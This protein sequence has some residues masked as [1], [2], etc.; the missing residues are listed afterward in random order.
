MNAR[1][2]MFKQ[3]DQALR[4]TLLA[5]GVGGAKIAE[6]LM[7]CH[8]CAQDG[9]HTDNPLKIIGNVADDQTFHGLWVSPDIDTL[10]YT[11]ADMIDR[12]KGWGLKGD[13]D[14]TLQAL[15]RLGRETWMFLGD[16]DFATHI[17]RTEQR[18]LGIRPSEIA[19][20]IARQL[21]VKAEILLPTDDVIQS[22]VSTDKGWLDFQDYFVRE[23][24][25][26]A[27]KS[28]TV[29]GAD[30]ATPTPEALRAIAEADLLVL[31]PSNPIASI[32]AILAVPGIRQAVVDTSA[33]RVAVSPLI[34]GKTVKGPADGM[35]RAAGFSS[36]VLGVADCYQGLIDGLLIDQLD[37]EAIPAL[38]ARGL[39]VLATDTLMQSRQN[40]IRVA[41]TLVQLYVGSGRSHP[42]ADV[43][44]VLSESL[45]AVVS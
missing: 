35:M 10:T 28:F 16:Q 25:E 31:A 40:K 36:D 15:K 26:P 37:R 6:G 24:C 14:H 27:V 21:G 45:R 33:Y 4:I 3:P 32:G 23:R 8:Y 42:P 39:D 17:Y 34:Q 5:G 7:H 18:A 41:E 12:D 30:N 19:A 44:A 29:I 13:T 20:N 22:W 2:A 1:A 43:Q 9:N 38:Q 11:L